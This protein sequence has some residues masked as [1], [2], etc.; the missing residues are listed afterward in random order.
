MM[1]ADDEKDSNKKMSISD[2]TRHVEEFS[3]EYDRHMKE[4]YAWADSNNIPPEV[5]ILK[6]IDNLREDFLNY[7]LIM[8]ASRIG[9]KKATEIAETAIEELRKEVKKPKDSKDGKDTVK[10]SRPYYIG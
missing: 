3:K 2:A 8:S 5:F 7:T 6:M 1:M 9:V 10:E 4:M